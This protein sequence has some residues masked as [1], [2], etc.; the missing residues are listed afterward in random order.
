MDPYTVYLMDP[1]DI[2]VNLHS[3]QDSRTRL[4]GHVVGR[5]CPLHDLLG[6]NGKESLFGAKV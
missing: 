5:P 4:R 1:L 3:F 6:F 2:H